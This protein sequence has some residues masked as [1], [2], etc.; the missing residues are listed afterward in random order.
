VAAYYVTGGRY[1]AQ[2]PLCADSPND[3]GLLLH[4]ATA[5]RRTQAGL[6]VFLKGSYSSTA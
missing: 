6:D 1:S 5:R 2:M 4:L 3:T